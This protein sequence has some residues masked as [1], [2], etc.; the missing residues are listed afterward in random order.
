[1]DSKKAMRIIGILEEK[2]DDTP[3]LDHANPL[4]LL[5]ATI[6]SAQST[7]AQINK[8]TPKLFKRY[9]TARDYA[10]SDIR[11]LEVLIHSSGF[12]HSKAKKIKEACRMII[13][14]FEG[15]VPDNMEDL[16]KLPGVG[17]KTANI[18][19]THAFGKVVGIAVDTH[20]ARV[21][22]R[23]GLSKNKDANKIEADL[24]KLIPKEKWS[25]VNHLLIDHGRNICDAKKPKCNVCPVNE[26]CKSAPVFL[27]KHYG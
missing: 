27:D 13:D 15:K 8:I 14:D 23:L 6:L 5:V 7:D 25:V 21:S 17:R 22:S 24:L 2:T 10:E 9:K 26:L 16:T 4:Q 18:V 20:V 1:M 19:L 12:Y 11:E 3:K